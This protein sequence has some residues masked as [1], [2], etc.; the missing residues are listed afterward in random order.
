VNEIPLEVSRPEVHYPFASHSVEFQAINIASRGSE[1]DFAY[2]PSGPRVTFSERV[3]SDVCVYEKYDNGF[4]D[5][6][7]G[8]DNIEKKPYSCRR[9]F[10]IDRGLEMVPI[11]DSV[12][13]SLLV[14]ESE[15]Y[16]PG[17][18]GGY[19]SFS[20]NDNICALRVVKANNC[21]YSVRGSM[22]SDNHSTIIKVQNVVEKDSVQKVMF[23]VTSGEVISSVNYVNDVVDLYTV[24]YSLPR[25]F[26][27]VKLLDRS[28]QKVFV[29]KK[30]L[31]I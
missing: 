9:P 27:D 18:T 20:T 30:F 11:T 21:S 3:E 12:V 31:F 25:D 1:Y 16:V 29:K 2:K 15:P 4:L 19:Y 13:G 6:M 23:N 14:K 22:T 5:V 28:E 17:G 8:P 7:K 26:T 24:T 10:L